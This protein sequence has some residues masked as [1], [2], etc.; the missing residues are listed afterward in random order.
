M[1]ASGRKYSKKH[2]SPYPL[3]YQW[4]DS[5]SFTF[6][7]NPTRHCLIVKDARRSTLGRPTACRA[8]CTCCCWP[9]ASCPTRRST[10]TSRR[11]STS[12]PSWTSSSRAT[13]GLRWAVA[14]GTGCPTGRAP[15]Q[16][17]P[18][19]IFNNQTMSRRVFYKCKTYRIVPLVH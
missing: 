17:T 16:G 6:V 10:L 3:M 19:G 8:S 2:H 15:R 11:A 5:V 9:G 18:A 13:S 7:E 12:W 14:A 4:H 1:I